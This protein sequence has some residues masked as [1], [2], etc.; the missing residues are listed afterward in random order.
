MFVDEC[1]AYQVDCHAV[2]LEND[3]QAR[4]RF[5]AVADEVGGTFQRDRKDRRYILRRADDRRGRA[6]RGVRFEGRRGTRFLQGLQARGKLLGQFDFDLRDVRLAALRGLREAEHRCQTRTIETTC[7]SRGRNREGW[8][9]R[10]SSTVGH[11]EVIGNG[12]ARAFSV[13]QR[14]GDR[15]RFAVRRV[16]R[17]T[18]TINHGID[19]PQLQRDAIEHRRK[20]VGRH[21]QPRGMRIDSDRRADHHRA[22]AGRAGEGVRTGLRRDDDR[23]AVRRSL[24]RPSDEDLPAGHEEGLGTR[25]SQDL[26]VADQACRAARPLRRLRFTAKLDA[27]QHARQTQRHRQLHPRQETISVRAPEGERKRG[28]S[29]GLDVRRLG[30]EGRLELWGAATGHFEGAARRRV[31]HERRS[32]MASGRLR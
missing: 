28:E 7:M 15:C 32:S 21:R 27:R 24:I 4:E 5:A 13:A 11:L 17:K 12:H 3:D 9:E 2:A 22:G 30:C 23:E 8:F 1:R 26:E 29:A 20:G 19:D 25:A 18:G 16:E 31:D 14:P 10:Q 6:V